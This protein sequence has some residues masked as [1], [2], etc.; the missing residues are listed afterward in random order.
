MLTFTLAFENLTRCK[1]NT[2]YSHYT[3]KLELLCCYG[4]TPRDMA[5]K[6]YC[7]LLFAIV[8]QCL[9]SV[10]FVVA[11]AC[12]STLASSFVCI[13]KLHIL[14]N[15]KVK[16]VII[17]N[18]LLI[19]LR[20]CFISMIIVTLNKGLKESHTKSAILILSQVQIKVGLQHKF[21]VSSFF[22]V[23]LCPL[24]KAV[25]DTCSGTVFSILPISYQPFL[26]TSLHYL[27]FYLYF[28]MHMQKISKTKNEVLSPTTQRA[29]ISTPDLP[30]DCIYLILLV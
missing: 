23:S 8:M 13:I 16:A 5:E 30:P 17:K 22:S 1:F 2:V 12:P 11:P 19:T 28:F 24:E 27:V 14:K 6:S 4:P 25:G 7:P 26:M 15:V 3:R 20:I 29:I 18:F 21:Y 9:I 10:S